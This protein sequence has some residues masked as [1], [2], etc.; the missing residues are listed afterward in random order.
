MWWREQNKNYNCAR[1][2]YTDPGQMKSLHVYTDSIKQTAIANSL[3]RNLQIEQKC[4]NKAC[5]QP[6]PCVNMEKLSI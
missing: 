3:K 1:I 5:K 4:L 6:Q 2:S